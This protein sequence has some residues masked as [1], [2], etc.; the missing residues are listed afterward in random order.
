MVR[1]Q[2]R[3]SGWAAALFV[4]AGAAS[5]GCA[6]DTNPS[7]AAN[8]NQ[9]QV[10]VSPMPY[11]VAY[12][13]EGARP[14]WASEGKSLD[15]VLAYVEGRPITRRRLIREGGGRPPGIEDEAFER[16]LQER[17]KQRVVEELFVREA[18]RVGLTL[19]E[20]ALDEV[21]AEQKR[22]MVEEAT[23]TEGRPVR[24]EEIL[25]DLDVTEAEY[26]DMFR[27][28][29]LQARYMRRILTG[30]GPLRPQ[31]EMEVSPA[32]VK[33]IHREHPGAFDVKPGVRFAAFLPKFATYLAGDRPVAEAEAAMNQAAARIAEALRRG[34]DPAAVAARENLARE[35]REWTE[36]AEFVPQDAETLP[37]AFG[38][39]AVEWLFAPG[40]RPRDATVL[41]QPR[42]E[43]PLVLGVLEVQAARRRDWDEVRDEI[44]KLVRLAREKR[45]EANLVI[46]M[47]SQRNVVW[48]QALADAIVEEARAVL[49]RLDRE[50]V[51]GSARFQ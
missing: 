8:P 21:M 7:Q 34:E 36:T 4:A 2:G 49:A 10:R 41:E 26:R 19:P 1:A 32:E 38:E 3:A 11:G 16:Q 25:R 40:R 20:Q 51:L 48:P 44:V 33:R 23:K 12:R 14:A 24:F 31:V 35:R 5:G 37:Q 9:T 13:P 30:G 43:G 47:V 15:E 39:A 29:I 45:V 18:E 28:R 42:G 22:K 27:R 46:Q 17:L 50:P 6:A